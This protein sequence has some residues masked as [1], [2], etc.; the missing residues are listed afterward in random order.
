LKKYRLPIFVVL[1]VLFLDQLL[2]I[3]VKTHFYLEQE[4]HITSWFSLYFIENEGMAFGMQLGGNYG[5][6]L[7]SLFRIAAVFFISYYIIKLVNKKAHRGLI[8]CFSLILAGALGNILDSIFYG[9]IFSESLPD[10]MAVLFPKGGGY[11]NWLHGNV[12]DMLYF[13][14]FQGTFPKWFPIWGGDQF[15]FFRDIFNIADASISIG[16]MLILLFQKKFY[17]KPI[18]V[19]ENKPPE[20]TNLPDENEFHSAHELK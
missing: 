15:L 18:P 12:V 14:L 5:K 16:V 20:Q 4:K 3:W 6:L 8:F 19:Q 7:L 13:P 17:P 1:G 11:T 9:V 10:K 2:K